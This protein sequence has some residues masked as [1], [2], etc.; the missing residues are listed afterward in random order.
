MINAPDS[1]YRIPRTNKPRT[2]NTSAWS[3][4]I[5]FDGEKLHAQG[6]VLVVA[7]L[8][9]RSEGNC[10]GKSIWKTNVFAR[11]PRE[12]RDVCCV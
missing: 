3:F 11:A 12:Q 9:R 5:Y 2:T 8:R 6:K 4:I 10:E 7:Q 1:L